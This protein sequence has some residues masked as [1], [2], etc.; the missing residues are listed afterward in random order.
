MVEA[1]IVLSARVPV[2]YPEKPQNRETIEL[3]SKFSARPLLG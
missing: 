3:P 2:P 1:I